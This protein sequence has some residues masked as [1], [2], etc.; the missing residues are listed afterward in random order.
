MQERIGCA[1]A[2]IA[3]NCMLF[4]IKHILFLCNI[5][6]TEKHFDKHPVAVIL[7]LWRCKINKTPKPSYRVGLILILTLYQD[8]KFNA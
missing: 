5:L 8:I 6:K 4:F 1:V 7:F 3:H 2:Q